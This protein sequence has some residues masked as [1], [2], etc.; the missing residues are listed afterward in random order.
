[1]TISDNKWQSTV[2]GYLDTVNNDSKNYRK[3]RGQSTTDAKRTELAGQY[4]AN[5]QMEDVLDLLCHLAGISRYEIVSDPS[6]LLKVIVPDAEKRPNTQKL[7]KW[8][9]AGIKA[10]NDCLAKGGSAILSLRHKG[11]GETGTHLITIQRISGDNV[12]V[13]DPYGGMRSDYRGDVAG[14]AYADPGKSRSTSEYRNVRHDSDWEDWKSGRAQN[15][16]DNERRG[17]S[18]T[19]ASDLVKTYFNYITLY[20]RAAN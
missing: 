8:D 7:W 3:L 6:R 13:D 10:V 1:M 9:A 11:K 19:L 12:I 2:K 14:D 15:L 16:D 17:E 5:A 20:H 18:H 4:K